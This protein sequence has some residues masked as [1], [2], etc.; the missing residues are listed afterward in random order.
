MQV[1]H[2]PYHPSLLEISYVADRKIDLPTWV[3]RMANEYEGDIPHRVGFNFPLT[4]GVGVDVVG[5]DMSIISYVI[6]YPRHDAETYR[7]E[8]LHFLYHHSRLYRRWVDREWSRMSPQGIQKAEKRMASMG[9]PRE[10]WVDEWQAYTFSS[11][12]SWKTIWSTY[13]EV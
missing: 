1:R 11:P 3:Y 7:H 13:E 12:S 10:R 5:V 8:L 4:S 9:Y 6:V 2:S